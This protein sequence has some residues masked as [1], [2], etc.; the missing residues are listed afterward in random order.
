M[1]QQSQ[2]LVLRPSERIA[3]PHA[4]SES[5]DRVA[6]DAPCHPGQPE[7]AHDGQDEREAHLPCQRVAARHPDRHE[8]RRERRQDGARRSPRCGPPS[9]LGHLTTRVLL[10][11]LR[12][13]LVLPDLRERDCRLPAH[14]AGRHGSHSRGHPSRRPSVSRRGES[15]GRADFTLA[16]RPEVYRM[17]DKWANPRRFANGQPTRMSTTG[18]A[19]SASS[20]WKYSRLRKPIVPAMSTLGKVWIEVLKSRTVLL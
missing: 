1:G 5:Q 12:A 14:V 13:S 15:T 7:R 17:V 16:G 20:I 9:S 3:E 6:V 11:E 19:V 8:D 10:A 4:S 2:P 18:T